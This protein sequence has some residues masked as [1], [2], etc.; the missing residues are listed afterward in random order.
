MTC[1]VNVANYIGEN[2]LSVS[3]N[4]PSIL[5][6]KKN[7]TESS[8][9]EFK[10]IEEEF[11]S[12]QINRGC[13]LF[14]V[15]TKYITSCVLKTSEFSRVRSTSEKFDVFNPRDDIYLVFTEKR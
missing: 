11:R 15:N 1:F 13:L 4:H 6:I 2:S 3:E 8:C 12:K 7:L 5:K 10:P 9:F 14:E